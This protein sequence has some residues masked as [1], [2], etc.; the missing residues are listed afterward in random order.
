[1]DSKYGPL[2]SAGH[3]EIY[4]EKLRITGDAVSALCFNSRFGWSADRFYQFKIIEDCVCLYCKGEEGL[5][6]QHIVMPLG[7][8]TPEKIRIIADFYMP[9]FE[10]AGNLIKVMFVPD[11]KIEIFKSVKGYDCDVFNSADFDEY[12]YDTE[13]LI[14]LKG[15]QLKSKKNLLNRFYRDCMSCEFSALIKEN[16]QEC[17]ELTEK[18]CAER[19]IDKNDLRSSD[20]IPIKIMFDNFDALDIRGGVIK[21]HKKMIAFFIGS[22]PLGDTGFIH[23][24]KVDQVVSGANVAIVVAALE[25]TFADVKYINREE[26]MGIEGLRTAKQSYMPAYMTHKND[27]F[28]KK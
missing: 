14:G 3:K 2:L 24:E 13:S 11:N 8:I 16:M 6:K 22:E 5:A 9:E 20:Y 4:N 26:D 1:M 23:F 21:L 18:W 27:V 28:L 19:G 12:V 25:N 15:K 10:A 17:L 7:E